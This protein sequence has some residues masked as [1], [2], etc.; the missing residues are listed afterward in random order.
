MTNPDISPVGFAATDHPHSPL[1]RDRGVLWIV[2]G[3]MLVLG[4]VVGVASFVWE[5]VAGSSGAK[6]DAV[7]QGQIAGLFA[8]P[9][10]P[11]SFFVEVAGP[12]T[13]W[14]D[15]GGVIDS[16]T[17][18]NIVAAANCEATFADGTSTSFRGAIQGSSVQVGDM[19]TVGTFSAPVG[20]AEVA[21]H[22]ERFG[23]RADRD[24]LQ[25]ERTFYVT[26]G[27]PGVGWTSWVGMFVGIP[28]VVLGSMAIARGSTGG[29]R[30]RK[31]RTRGPVAPH[32]R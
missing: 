15:D 14:L 27:S 13:V 28:A 5:M 6:D 20:A 9:T 12:Y 1:E 31:R 26:P 10:P 3:V 18:D 23:R 8:T 30:T 17:R 29:V 11:A 22:S 4:G 21:C 2:L 32:E 7:A 19:A 25:Q 16:G 24:Q